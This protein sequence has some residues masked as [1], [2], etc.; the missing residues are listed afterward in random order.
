MTW[1]SLDLDFGFLAGSS[2]SWTPCLLHSFQRG[3]LG[4]MLLET[5]C[6]SLSRL[7]VWLGIEF[8]VVLLP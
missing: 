1:S 6:V 8:Q 7:E 4:E 5:L 2:A 3:R